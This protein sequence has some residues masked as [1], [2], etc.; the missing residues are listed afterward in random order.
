MCL[1]LAATDILMWLSVCL[2]CARACACVQVF[3]KWVGESERAV[4]EVFRKARA[5]APCIVF[6]DEIDAVALRRGSSGDSS[7]SDRVLSQLLSEL[8]GV[9]P[10]ADVVLLAATNRPDALVPFCDFVVFECG[11]IRCVWADSN[12]GVIAG[13]GANAPWSH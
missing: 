8:D 3:S 4:R 12:L 11:F 13:P 9:R 6:F 1:L 7:V 10:L 2:L 5:A